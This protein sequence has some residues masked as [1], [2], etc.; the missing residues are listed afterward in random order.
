MAFK[1]V[2]E[3]EVRHAGLGKYRHI[4]GADRHVVEQKAFAQQRQWDDQW[5]RQQEARRRAEAK[6]AERERLFREKTKQADRERERREDCEHEATERT[7]AATELLDDL[8]DTLLNTLAVDDAIDW[9]ALK[10]SASFSERPPRMARPSAPVLHPLADAP[11]PLPM[12]SRPEPSPEPPPPDPEDAHFKPVFGLLDKLSATRRQRRIDEARSRYEQACSAREAACAVVRKK[13]QARIA[14]W[15][16]EIRRRESINAESQENW[17][18]YKRQRE[19]EYGI[20]VAE[21]KRA[22]ADAEVNFSSRRTEWETRRQQFLDGQAETNAAVD[23]Q[24]AAWLKGEP[25]AVIDYCEMVL[26]NSRYPDCIPREWDIDYLEDTRTLLVEFALPA[27]VD[28]PTLRE[29]KYLSTKDEFK[30]THLSSKEIAALYDDLLYKIAL[31]T[32]HELFEA[33]RAEALEAVVFNGLVTAVDKSTGNPSTLCVLS[34]Q[35]GKAD[36]LAINLAQIDPKACFK[37]LKGVGSSKLHGMTAIPPIAT[38]D[39]NDRRFVDAYGVVNGIDASTNLAAM[40]WEDFEHLIREVFAQE[41]SSSGS[42][43]RV[44]QAS[45]DGGVDA[46]AFD[47]D[48]IRGGKIVIQ[49]KRY[50]NTVGVSAVRDLYG[51]VMNEGAIKGILVSTAN[52]GPDAYEFAKG[53]PL[54]LLNG[55]NLLHLLEKHGHRARINLAE[56]KRR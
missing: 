54:A 26:A 5:A 45:R 35:A 31:R 21:W 20:R 6:E 44:T 42:E 34:V 28:L 55:G 37:S 53:K 19:A 41:F 40:D 18:K 15:R 39:K 1:I 27:P 14:S 24:C 49:A 47:S 25:D 46:I 43:V 3:I 11:P 7:E 2:Y 22:C 4:K 10:E 8:R 12:P 50:T 23:R 51:T 30:E 38:I 32:L 17:E 9:N 29:V 16:A 13:S 56:A 36:F 48:P 52:F 33:D